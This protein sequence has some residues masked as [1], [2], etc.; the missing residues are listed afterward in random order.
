MRQVVSE[1]WGVNMVM[2][3]GY[4]LAVLLACGLLAG[5]AVADPPS[6][7]ARFVQI[8]IQGDTQTGRLDDGGI[9][10]GSGWMNRMTWLPATEQPRTYFTG[11]DIN[12]LTWTRV[13]FAFTPQSDGIVT[14]GFSGPWEEASPGQV[15]RQEVAIDA[16]ATEGGAAGFANGGFEAMVSGEP[17][18]WTWSAGPGELATT[19]PPPFEGESSAIVWTG[20]T[21]SQSIAV[22][23]GVPVRIW[24][25]AR[26]RTP[27]GFVEKPRLPSSGTPAHA[28]MAHF[29]RGVNLGNCLEA[30]PGEDW[31]AHYTAA[32]FD[33]IAAQGFDHVRIPAAWHYHTGAGPAYTI[34]NAFFAQ[35]DT[36]VTN[37]LSRGLHVIVNIHHFN[38]FTE[39]PSART[40][41]FYALWEQIAGHYHSTPDMLAFE[42]LNE[43]MGNATTEVMNPIHAEAI[44]RIRA[45]SPDRLIFIGPGNYNS[46]AELDNLVLPPADSNVVVTVHDYSPFY[47]THQG[48]PWTHPA[49]ATTNIVYPGPP[50][51]PVP[52]HP[53]TAGDQGVAAWLDRYNR[54]ETALNPCSREAWRDSLAYVRAWSDHYGRPV[55]VGE[56]G[57]Y[58]HMDAASR[59]R[60][61]TEKRVDLDAHHLPWA[62]WDWKSGFRYWDPDAGAPM[63]GLRDAILPAPVIGQ[64]GSREFSASGSIGRRYRWET[65]NS[66]IGDPEWQGGEIEQLAANA[67]VRSFTSPT[68]RLFICV[69]WLLP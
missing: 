31:G 43:P 60:F 66:L 69:R 26:A 35:V 36:L 1:Q 42:L 67:S 20:N 58:R 41:M 12:R 29:M 40:N 61:H 48:T 37:A 11:I 3:S 63:E 32:D 23:G 24:L 16:V 8:N 59:R 5:A 9:I 28:S 22:T 14:V 13:G 56:W 44:A 50:P 54:L 51:A 45:V 39:N 30:P 19:N 52:P 38:D 25:Q 57:A 10:R 62:L 27:A 17:V 47:F 15:W 2:S 33:A 55:H 21:L 6:K 68:G 18:G 4:R 49:C 53:D 64:A 7:L 65:A 34:S 46:I